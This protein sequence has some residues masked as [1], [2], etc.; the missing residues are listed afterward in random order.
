M[1]ELVTIRPTPVVI[2]R[3]TPTSYFPKKVHIKNISSQYVVFNI[4]VTKALLSLHS[5]NPCRSFIAPNSE[6]EITI[7]RLDTEGPKDYKFLIVFYSVDRV[8]ESKEMAKDILTKQQYNKN[9][10]Q[11]I[12]LKIL[13]DDDIR[14][15]ENITEYETKLQTE[16]NEEEKIRMYKIINDGYKT[17][18]DDLETKIDEV[19]QKLENIKKNKELIKQK[20]KGK[21]Y[22]NFLL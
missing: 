16:E 8:V 20:E 7:K 9:S 10:K 12:T 6:L 14:D 4:F 17:K 11:E 22:F 2:H 3:Q 5:I 15:E 13:V 19:K 21:L 1:S 18:I